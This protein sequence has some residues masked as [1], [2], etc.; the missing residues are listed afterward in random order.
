MLNMPYVR[1]IE[2][3]ESRLIFLVARFTTF[4]CSSFIDRFEGFG[5]A[6]LLHQ[7]CNYYI[8]IECFNWWHLFVLMINSLEMHSSF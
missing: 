4:I 7:K 6:Q 5:G 8:L 3:D 2:R 1:D